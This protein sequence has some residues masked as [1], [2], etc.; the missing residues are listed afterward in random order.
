MLLAIAA[1]LTNAGL[2]A[3]TMDVLDEYSETVR[4]WVFV[5]FQWLCFSLQMIIME[6]IPDCPEEI[7]IQLQR[8]EFIERKLIDRVA[9]DEDEDL[10]G[11]EAELPIH[12][13]HVSGGSSS[14]YGIAAKTAAV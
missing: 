3:F 5:G 14:T 6:A 12:K 1:V 8:T 7:D 11:Q 2:I 10:V 13:H 9:D 4:Y